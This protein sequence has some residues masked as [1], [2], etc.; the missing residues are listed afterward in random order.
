MCVVALACTTMMTSCEKDNKDNNEDN[1]TNSEYYV[2][3][4]IVSTGFM[5]CSAIAYLNGPNGASNVVDVTHGTHSWTYGP[6]KYGNFLRIEIPASG[7]TEFGPS[8]VTANISVSKD[9]GPFAIKA[10]KTYNS[11]SDWGQSLVVT[12]TI[13]E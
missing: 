12:Y 4:E 5:Q 6:Y 2:Q 8:T 3:Y 10:T 7:L 9:G 1:T 13:S 11:A